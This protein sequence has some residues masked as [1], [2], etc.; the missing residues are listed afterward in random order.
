MLGYP[1]HA[2]YKTEILMAKS[3]ETVNTFL[4][5]LAEK[6]TPLWNEEK[7]YL[8]ELKEKEVKVFFYFSCLI[9]KVK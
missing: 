1:N 6:L 7:K 8:L 3:P 5:E 9:F 4:S 2:A